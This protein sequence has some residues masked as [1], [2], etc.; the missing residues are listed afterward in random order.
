MIRVGV[1]GC[2]TI[3][4]QLALSLERAYANVARVVALHDVDRRAALALT[5]RLTSHPPVVSLPRLIRASHLVL[6][7]AAA[8]VSAEVATRALRANRSV[9]V[10]SVGGLLRETRWRAALARSRGRLYSPSGALAG[11]DG[12]TAMAIGR[13][14]RVSLTTHKPPR[15]LA[16]APY[17]RRHKLRLERLTRPSVIFEGSPREVTSA[18]PQNTN[19][20]ATLLLAVRGAVAARGARVRGV[21]IRVRVVADPTIRMN[22]HE[23]DVQGDCGR[24]RCRVESR[25]SRNPKTSELAVRSALVTVGRMFDPFVVGT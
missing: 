22:V 2:G 15:A 8:D 1:V 23:L 12:I 9:L 3:G 19:V 7:A 10:M 4:S 14:R 17:V 16:Q 11:L 5:R 20:A 25:P 24:L 6:E 18:F 13:I 21:S